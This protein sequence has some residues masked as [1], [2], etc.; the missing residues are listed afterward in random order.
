MHSSPVC[1]PG[2]GETTCR[3]RCGAS[4]ARGVPAS[5]GSAARSH[6]SGAGVVAARGANAGAAGPHPSA[7]GAGEPLGAPANAGAV[8]PSACGAASARGVS[9]E[10]G[11]PSMP[12][13]TSPAGDDVVGPPGVTTFVAGIAAVAGVACVAGVTGAGRVASCGAMAASGN[14]IAIPAT[15]TANAVRRDAPSRFCLGFSKANKRPSNC[16]RR[17]IA[18]AT[19]Y[20]SRV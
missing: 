11:P 20:C 14:A 15:A 13:E 18:S 2:G 1:L 6:P 7:R 8:T 4:S 9:A 16:E 3:L 19:A 12:P 5:A 17:A 10:S